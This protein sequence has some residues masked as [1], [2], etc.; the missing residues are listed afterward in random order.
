[1]REFYRA[2]LAL[3][4][5]VARDYFLILLLTGLRRTEAAMLRWADIDLDSKTITILK[6]HTKNKSEFSIPMSSFVFDI[7][8]RRRQDP[9]RSEFVFPGRD[10]H[11]V[12]IGH[13]FEQVTEK[14]GCRIVPHDL[15]RTLITTAAKLGIPYPVIK[16]LVNHSHSGDITEGYVFLHVEHLREPM[17]MITQHFL[18]LFEFDEQG[19]KTASDFY[20]PG[21]IARYRAD[22]DRAV[23]S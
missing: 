8:M 15:R 19:W 1:M 14:I 22:K 20:R 7:M 18:R 21:F 6:Q 10:G 9:R 3:R 5:K 2:L 16:A 12:D 4:Q 17:E 23:E 11:L 13:C